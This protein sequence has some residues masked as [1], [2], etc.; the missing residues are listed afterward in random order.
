[1]TKTA[2]PTFWPALLSA[3]DEAPG[4]RTFR[5]ASP[6]RFAFTPGQFLMFHFADDPKTWRAYSLCSSP[7]AAREYFEVTVGMVGPFSERLGGLAPHAEGGLVVRGPFGKWIYDGS[8]PHA[9]LVAGGTGLSPFRAM[10]LLNG[11]MGLARKIT[12][13]CSAKTPEG[14][15]YRAEYDGWRMNGIDVK[16]K[17]TQPGAASNWTGEIGRW[18]AASVF[19]AANDAAA[20][21][22]LCGPNKMVQELR[23]GLQRIG[24]TP[25]NIRTEKWGDYTELF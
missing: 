8:A 11:E 16:E 12:L 17:I 25:E 2:H 5:F 14:L 24:I 20:V 13:C 6:E 7:H 9:V 15:L 23:D 18:T 19:A 21:Y 22:Y 10:C 1:M 3:R 4:A